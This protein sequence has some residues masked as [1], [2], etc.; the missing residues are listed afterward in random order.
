MA[1]PKERVQPAPAGA[2]EGRGAGATCERERKRTRYGDAGPR[3]EGG[4]LASNSRPKHG[5]GRREV[6]SR[7]F[8]DFA[9]IACQ[10]PPM[11]MRLRFPAVAAL[12][13]FSSLLAGCGE[14][15]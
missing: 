14:S 9:M 2:A 7:P 15:G 6:L 11:R 3:G 5:G 4:L 10:H 8:L 1:L 13:V 12:L